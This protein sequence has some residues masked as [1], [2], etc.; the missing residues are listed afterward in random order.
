MDLPHWIYQNRGEKK[1]KKKRK[2]TNTQHTKSTKYIISKIAVLT[3]FQFQ[4]VMWREPS[5]YT[6]LCMNHQVETF[7]CKNWKIQSFISFLG[8]GW[9]LYETLR[10]N[11]GKRNTT[12]LLRKFQS[13]IWRPICTNCGTDR[14]VYANGKP[15]PQ[16]LK[17][18]RQPWIVLLHELVAPPLNNLFCVYMNTSSVLLVSCHLDF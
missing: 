12:N 8:F 15:W 14:L 1:W 4:S 3:K 5:G 2:E 18:W 16:F 13:E 7:L 9:D 17:M 10:L 11:T 6:L